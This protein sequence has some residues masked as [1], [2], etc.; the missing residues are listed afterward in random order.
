MEM[1]ARSHLIPA[2][3]LVVPRLLL[4]HDMMSP[5][6]LLPVVCEIVV[7]LG[8]DLDLLSLIGQGIFAETIDGEEKVLA[9]VLMIVVATRTESADHLQGGMRG[10]DE[11]I[12]GKETGSTNEEGKTMM[13]DALRRYY[14]IYNASIAI[15][16]YAIL[17]MYVS[18][19]VCPSCFWQ[20]I[21]SFGFDIF[22][23]NIQ[24][25]TYTYS[26][27]ATSVSAS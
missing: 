16:F 7:Q 27:K 20:S 24:I 4:V 9:T 14:E 1:A 12:L 17:F 2:T 15:S 19:D 18:S 8:R 25:G 13:Y 21:G 11:W 26:A 22:Q 10:R 6:R 3:E 23:T 5:G